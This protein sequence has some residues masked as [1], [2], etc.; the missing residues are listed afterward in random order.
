MILLTSYKIITQNMQLKQ[1]YKNKIGCN[2]H[3]QLSKEKQ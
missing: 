1:W 2:F 3:Q